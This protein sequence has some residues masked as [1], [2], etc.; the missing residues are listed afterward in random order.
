MSVTPEKPGTLSA[1]AAQAGLNLFF[2]LVLRDR[3]FETSAFSPNLL[4]IG[5]KK[6]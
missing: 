1:E 4:F 6:H 5:R 3:G 2:R